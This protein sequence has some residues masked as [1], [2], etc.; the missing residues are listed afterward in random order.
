[1]KT[2]GILFEAFIIRQIT[3][4][5]VPKRL[6]QVDGFHER[7]VA[8]EIVLF[9]LFVAIDVCLRN[10]SYRKKILSEKL[11]VRKK[12]KYFLSRAGI[13][14]Y[15]ILFTLVYSSKEGIFYAYMFIYWA[16][17]FV[18]E[19]VIGMRFERGVLELSESVKKKH[20]I[21][22]YQSDICSKIETFCLTNIFLSKKK[23]I[24]V[25]SNY[26]FVPEYMAAVCSNEI[27]G[28]DVYF[29]TDSSL[30]NKLVNK[31]INRVHSYFINSAKGIIALVKMYDETKDVAVFSDKVAINKLTQKGYVLSANKISYVKKN[32]MNND[33][34]ENDIISEIEEGHVSFLEKEELKDLAK[35]EGNEPGKMEVARILSRQ[36]EFQTD[37]EYFY[38]LIKIAELMIHYQG[39][40][41]YEESNRHFLNNNGAISI[42]DFANAIVIHNRSEYCRTDEYKNAVD[43]IYKSVLERDSSFSKKK[44]ELSGIKCIVEVRNRLL[45]HGTM[46]YSVSGEITNAINEIVT[47]IINAFMLESEDMMHASLLNNSIEKVVQKEDGLYLLCAVYSDKQYEYFNYANGK[48]I[49]VGKP[50]VIDLRRE[51]SDEDI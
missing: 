1:M 10:R 9:I 37:T 8:I 39:L 26:V 44:P 16:I 5:F 46:V 2:L 51:K 3:S 4:I 40:A 33:P 31:K 25:I 28:A 36:K 45:G 41:C 21:V 43:L 47:G 23:R 19:K 50:V 13:S 48:R 30:W 20:N 29:V 6:A 27:N 38:S 32:V 15:L 7:L 49:T 12:M 11:T 22:I 14:P 18:T 35:Y 34:L 24:Q 42:G 17:V